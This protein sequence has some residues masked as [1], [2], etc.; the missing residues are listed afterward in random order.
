MRALVYHGHK[1]IRCEEVPD[2]EPVSKD[3]AK[4]CSKLCSTLRTERPHSLAASM[5]HIPEPF[6]EIMRK[7]KQ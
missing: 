5:L 6:A 1:D 3:G 7:M 4:A 2:P